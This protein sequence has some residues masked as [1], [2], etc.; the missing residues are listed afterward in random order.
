[1]MLERAIREQV[2]TSPA[3]R[4]A[5]SPRH[6]FF[7]EPLTGF[8]DG[9]DGIFQEYKKVIGDFHLTPREALEGHLADKGMAKVRP[10]RVSVVSLVLP[11]TRRT[12]RATRD[13]SLITSLPWNRTRW[14]GQE[15]IDGL[16][17]YVVSLLEEMGYQS[18]APELAKCYQT[19]KRPEVYVSNWSQRHVAYAAGLGTFGLNDG[20]ITPRGIAMRCASVVTDA[21]LIPSY[22]P[23]ENH[24][25]NCRHY[26]SG[27]CGRCI[28]RCPAG[29]ISERGHDK[30]ACQEFV[31]IRQ[32]EL[33]KE[34]G[35]EGY[36][37]RYPGCGLCQTGV[38]CEHKIPG[39]GRR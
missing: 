31:L 24:L 8:A 36:T 1:M 25:A 30:K 33:L 16:S 11:I 20:F 37:G 21:P 2:A 15:F 7:D 10:S 3:N 12:C 28:E 9:D 34:E 19:T 27:S 26:R 4:F 22:R 5:N 29:A 13:E 18:L 6:A 17:R 32:K 23:Y 39:G 38:P 35:R 14:Q